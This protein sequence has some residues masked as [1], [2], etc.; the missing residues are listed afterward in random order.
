[1]I[2][3]VTRLALLLAGIA[4]T[5]LAAVVAGS[6]ALDHRLRVRRTRAAVPPLRSAPVL[7]GAAAT[8]PVPPPRRAAIP[9]GA[10]PAAL[11]PPRRLA[12][13]AAPAP[14]EAAASGARRPRTPTPVRLA[15]LAVGWAVAGVGLTL[16]AALA[17]SCV[18]GYRSMTVMSGSMEPAIQTGDVVVNRPIAPLDARVG[19]VVTFREPGSG[20]RFI[21]HRVRRVSARAGK[22]TFVTK[23]DANTGTE[24]WTIP[25]DGEIGRVQFRLPHLGYA[26]FWTRGRYAILGLVTIPA[27]LLAAMTVARIWRSP[28]KVKVSRG[29]AA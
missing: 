14:R 24:R 3:R 12:A 6:L 11:V 29:A 1:M 7:A 2:R 13:P 18:A 23:G 10:A 19:D 5:A 16:L 15:G 8:A 25:A 27:L 9:A 17:V 20:A 22:V 28:A 21:T 4:A 26:L